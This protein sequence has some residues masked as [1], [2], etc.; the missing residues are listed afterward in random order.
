MSILGTGT[1]L[2][3]FWEGRG[4]FQKALHSENDFINLIE[5][6]FW[7]ME[8]I[9]LEV[10]VRHSKKKYLLYHLTEDRS[11]EMEQV[12]CI[13]NRNHKCT[14]GDRGRGGKEG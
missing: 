10:R 4:S 3:D 7:E 13:V 11:W 6:Q 12:F 5:R 1:D 9:C 8:R 2:F 14:Q